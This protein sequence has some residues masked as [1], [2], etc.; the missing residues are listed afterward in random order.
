MVKNKSFSE[1]R[2][3]INSQAGMDKAVESICDI[4]CPDKDK[5]A[6][7]VGTWLLVE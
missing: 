6:R 1:N 4:L 5:G 2:K 7:I 3:A